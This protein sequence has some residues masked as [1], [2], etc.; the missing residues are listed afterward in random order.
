[1]RWISIELGGQ[2]LCDL[3]LIDGL[4]LVLGC[5]GGLVLGLVYDLLLVLARLCQRWL[6]EQG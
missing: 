1:M 4:L 6:G 2:R 5:G 3:R